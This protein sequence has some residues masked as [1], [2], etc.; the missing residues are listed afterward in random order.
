MAAEL[1]VVALDVRPVAA[2]QRRSFSPPLLKDEAY[3]RDVQ[4]GKAL[5]SAWLPSCW[6]TGGR[7][8]KCTET[9]AQI[10]KSHSRSGLFVFAFAN[11]FELEKSSSNE[12]L[13]ILLHDSRDTVSGRHQALVR[14]V[15]CC[16]GS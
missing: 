6:A 15:S 16:C 2:T 11:V 12:L 7:A 9:V 14:N 13:F 1:F 3:P 8:N 4:K 10:P 5:A